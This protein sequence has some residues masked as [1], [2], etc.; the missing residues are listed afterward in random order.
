MEQALLLAMH[1]YRWS[2]R[3]MPCKMADVNDLPV[4]ACPQKLLAAGEHGH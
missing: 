1:A 3:E 4:I 2:G